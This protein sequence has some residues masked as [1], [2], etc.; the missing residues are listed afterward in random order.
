MITHVNSL[1]TLGFGK[2]KLEKE[3][4][5][6]EKELELRKK[7]TEKVKELKYLGASDEVIKDF[8]DRTERIFSIKN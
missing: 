7:I 5:S 6:I 2:P 8:L 4:I 1:R 3:K